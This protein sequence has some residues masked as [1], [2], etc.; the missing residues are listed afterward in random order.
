MRKTIVAILAAASFWGSGL[1]IGLAQS[2]AALGPD[3]Q[4]VQNA[5]AA[6]QQQRNR[7]QD[8]AAQAQAQLAVVQ[9]QLASTK[10]ELDDLKAANVPKPAEPAKK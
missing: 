8:E 5:L 10:K 2:G 3:P 7:A 6:L 1:A 9:S 4:F